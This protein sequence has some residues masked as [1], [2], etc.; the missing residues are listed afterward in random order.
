MPACAGDPTSDRAG[1]S[2]IP[3]CGWLLVRGWSGLL[4]MR[5]EA[6]GSPH[7]GERAGRMPA[8]EFAELR[9]ASCEAPDKECGGESGPVPDSPTPQV[10][11]TG[12]CGESPLRKPCR[13]RQRVG[14]HI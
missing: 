8:L 13:L 9:E 14:T 10:P 5:R 4:Y 2:V 6:Q 3:T 1:A 11:W 12:I 7:R